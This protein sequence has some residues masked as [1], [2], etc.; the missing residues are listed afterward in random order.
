M[1]NARDLLGV[2]TASAYNAELWATIGLCALRY[3]ASIAD[4]RRQLAKRIF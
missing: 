3:C 1:G 4:L 2:R